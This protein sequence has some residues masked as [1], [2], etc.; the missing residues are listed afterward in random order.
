MQTLPDALAPMAAYRQFINYKLVPHPKKPGKM[1]KLPVSPLTGA[2][3]DAHDRTHW[4]DATS[5]L[6]CG[7]G[8]GLAFVFAESDPFFF[9]DIDNC[10]ED[11]GQ[12]SALAMQ[13][14]GALPSCAVEV[15]SSGRGLHIF[16]QYTGIIQHGCKNVALGLELYHTERFVALTG[17]NAIGSAATDVTAPLTQAVIPFYFP[18]DALPLDVAEWTNAPIAEWRGPTDD[19]DLLR[20]ALRS[21]SARGAFGG[22]ATFA[23]LWNADVDA[24]AQAYPGDGQGGYDESAADAA[25]SQH[26]AFWTGNNCERITS[27]MQRSCLKRDK[28]EREDYL[29][30][31]ILGSV[32]RQTSV[33]VDK[34][35]IP[36]QQAEPVMSAT[37]MEHEKSYL[38]LPEQMEFFTGCTY[39]L[40]MH[41]VLTAG[42]DLLKPDQ[43]RVIY[44]ART[45]VM[46]ALNEKTT[47]DAWEAFTQN[48]AIRFPRAD[49]VT[50]RPDRPAGDIFREHGRILANSY[51]PIDIPRRAGDPSKFLNHIAKLLPDERDRA[52]LMAYMAACVQ[53]KGVK[54]QWAPLIQ[55]AEGNGKS[56]LS[57]CVAHAIGA[58]YVHWPS[59]D[60]LTAQFNGWML[61]KLF[62]AVED[63]YVPNSR[64][65][66][67]ERLKPMIT[68]DEIEIEMKG[69]DQITAHVCCNFMLNSNHKGAVRKTLND[70]R[71]AHFYTAQQNA[72]DVYRDGM[73][74]DYFNSLYTW[75]RAEGYAIVSQLL[76]DW[77]IPDEFNPATTCHRAPITSSTQEAL[78]ASRGAVEQHILEA[79]EQGLSGFSGGWISSIML[80][81]LLEK[82]RLQ[83]RVP[84]N[85]RREL[86]QGLGYDWHPGLKQGRVDNIVLPDGGKPRLFVTIGHESSHLTGV[87]VSRAYSGAQ[88]A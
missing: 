13:L 68:A 37:L 29:P 38:N 72:A 6:A 45:F 17:T 48:R 75:M 67:I 65:E 49:S 78:E 26:L 87:D 62:C 56:L 34:E 86:L 12:W 79:I 74:G 82:N 70:R 24:L 46:D 14:L 76:H 47:N 32:R 7:Y 1:N 77:P 64:V 40:D 31:T 35:V 73:G 51:V 4:T 42:G 57:R 15:S 16:G 59:A 23:E 22:T 53:Y 43:F 52:I 41:R 80:D 5:A 9:L 44:G 19:E 20:R 83:D 85:R 55:G 71:F 81:R 21:Q 25:L 54:F 2:V 63:I 58:K 39:I 10:L 60:K 18:A 50:F 61:G 28:W 88:P 8:D 66:V 27:L 3:V 30:R 33:L 11:S 36:P 69:V 84:L